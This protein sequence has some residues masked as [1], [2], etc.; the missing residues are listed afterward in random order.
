M[1]L[2]NGGPLDCVS[3]AVI[4]IT[5]RRMG[6]FT[7]LKQNSNKGREMGRERERPKER[8]TKNYFHKIKKQ[9]VKQQ[10]WEQSLTI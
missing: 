10:M 3:Q 8:M 9:T 2:F 4:D 1:V 7:G 5:S 6:D